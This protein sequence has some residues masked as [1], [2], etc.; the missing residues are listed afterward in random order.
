MTAALNSQ[1]VSPIPFS[2]A[3]LGW[4]LRHQ[5][6]N[7]LIVLNDGEFDSKPASEP[8]HYVAN[9]V[10]DLDDRSNI[11]IVLGVYRRAGN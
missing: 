6:F 2:F 11:G 1:P 7:H 5:I 8:S 10:S 3:G 9:N 4:R